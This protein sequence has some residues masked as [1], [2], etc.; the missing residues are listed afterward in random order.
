M[1]MQTRSRILAALLIIWATAPAFAEPDA[2]QRR[3]IAGARAATEA[4]A[5]ANEGA[6]IAD[7]MKL[8]DLQ[9]RL[10]D[11][12]GAAATRE[13][14]RRAIAASGERD[15]NWAVFARFMA[16]VGQDSEAEAAVGRI[17]NPQARSDALAGLV[18]AYASNGAR[19]LALAWIARLPEGAPRQQ[20]AALASQRA[21]SGRHY[22]LAQNFLAGTVG[23]DEAAAVMIATSAAGNGDFA[24]AAAAA[25]RVRDRTARIR[26][27]HL[28]GS[29][30]VKAGR[31]DEALAPLREAAGLV[32]SLED[33]ATRPIQISLLA[34]ELAAAGDFD[35]ALSLAPLAGEESA[36][37]FALIATQQARAGA[38][39]ASKRTQALIS[40]NR[41]DLRAQAEADRL[42]ERIL[43][44]LE[45]VAAAQRIADPLRRS[46]SLTEAGD[47]ACSRGQ[48]A[49][50][51]ELLQQARAAAATQSGEDR[52]SALLDVA[53][54]Q[55]D[56]GLGEDARTSA[57]SILGAAD[58]ADALSGAAKALA[59]AGARAEAIVTFREALDAG[60][61]RMGAEDYAYITI[62]MAEAGLMDEALSAARALPQRDF[63]E[64][65]ARQTALLGVIAALTAADRREA[66]M[67]LVPEIPARRAE[68]YRLIA[69]EQPAE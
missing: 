56:C 33:S 58:R 47:H 21:A 36:P 27:L 26:V 11:G 29:E 15:A 18:D 46:E 5:R 54:A 34:E 8:H 69:G 28:L 9:S 30:L 63:D 49:L 42:V 40:S 6:W 62:M 32:E 19:D 10:G 59:E 61:G 52:D 31:K 14:M 51:A 12:S 35:R 41:D 50:G 43:R 20:A 2:I 16:K 64:R 57:R 24:D 38:F 13:A 25:A 60:R 1:W 66:A 68:A 55:E 22:A 3:T 67:A 39:E 37:L 65:W 45:P 7:F 44:G 48:R 53:R 4:A 23:G 17:A